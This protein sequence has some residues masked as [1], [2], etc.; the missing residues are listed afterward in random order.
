MANYPDFFGGKNLEWTKISKKCQSVKSLLKV[1]PVK[2]KNNNNN[3]K[4]NN[5]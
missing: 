2:K 3:N 5:K 4:K 1:K